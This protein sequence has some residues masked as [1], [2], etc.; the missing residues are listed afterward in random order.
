MNTENTNIL[1]Y[2]KKPKVIYNNMYIKHGKVAKFVFQ[3]R[4][5]VNMLIKTVI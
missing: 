2:G 5:F 3:W 4:I 1:F